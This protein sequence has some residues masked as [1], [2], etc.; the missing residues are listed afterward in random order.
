MDRRHNHF[1]YCSRALLRQRLNNGK[2]L[3]LEHTLAPYITYIDQRQ[4]D[5]I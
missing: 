3:T 5:P 4:K 1:E 2:P